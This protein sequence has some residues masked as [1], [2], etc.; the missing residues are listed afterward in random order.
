MDRKGAAK[1]RASVNRT[2]VHEKLDSYED[3]AFDEYDYRSAVN[4]SVEFRRHEE[5]FMP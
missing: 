4:S 2:L 5:T 1:Q 3:E